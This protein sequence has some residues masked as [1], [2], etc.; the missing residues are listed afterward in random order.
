MLTELEIAKLTYPFPRDDH[1]FLQGYVYISEEAIGERIEKVDPE[2]RFSIDEMTAL[3]DSIVVRAT[4]TIR[5][6]SRSN[7]GGNPV[8][9]DK[10]DKATNVYNPLPLYTQA[11][12]G[13]NA[14]KAAATDAFKRCARLFGI[15]RYLLGAPKEGRSFDEWLVTQ[16]AAAKAALQALTAPP[17]Q[18]DTITG[19][20]TPPA[21]SAAAPLAVVPKAEPSGSSATSPAS[22]AASGNPLP[23]VTVAADVSD[24]IDE[25]F[26]KREANTITVSQVR[27][28]KTDKGGRVL[29]FEQ[30]GVKVLSFTREPLRDVLAGDVLEQLAVV[31]VYEIPSVRLMYSLDGKFLKLDKA[32]LV[33]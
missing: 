4:M 21:P 2:W 32:E 30:G 16:T 29:T 24:A 1:S 12:N 28:G 8:Q 7:I 6:V 10:L 31:G 5:G 3:S 26:G 20:I 22:H 9:R 23:T 27:V 14:Y 13:V 18:V 15:G 17:K 33:A 25:A 19:E 11:D